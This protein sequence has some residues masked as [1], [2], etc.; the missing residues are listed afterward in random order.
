[1]S[2][3]RVQVV[4]FKRDLRIADHAPLSLAA[5]RGPVLPLYVV[6]PG[7]WQQPDMAARHWAFIGESLHELNEALAGLGQPLVVR[8]GDVVEV[9]EGLRKSLHIDALWSHEETGNAWSYRRDERVRAYLAARGIN[10]HELPQNGVVRRLA[11]RDGW[12]RRWE[13]RMSEPRAVPPAALLPLDGLVTHEMPGPAALGLADDPCPGRQPGGRRAGLER[14]GSFLDSRG[15]NYHTGMSSPVTA[16][17][18]CSRLSPHLAWGCL[19]IREVVQACRERRRE[20]KAQPASE[21]GG[22]AKALAAFEGR[23]HW[24]CHFIQK[25]ESEP[26]IEFENLHRA[27]DGLREAE[28]DTARFG[29]WC[30]AETGFPF[31]DACLRALEATG[32]I[33]FRMRA[34]L[35]SFASYH[36]W[37]HWREP[38]LFLARRFTDYEPGI[39]YAQA[40]MQAG[41]TGINTFRIY[42]PVK[43]SQDQDPSGRFIRE[44]LP[45]LARVEE[46]W[47]HTPWLM[48]DGAQRDSGCLIGRDYPEPLVDH[49]AAARLARQRMGGLR[50]GRARDESRRILER[51]GS[52]RGG[53]AAGGPKAAGDSP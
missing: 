46:R 27:C 50:R 31:V 6:E 48:D 37:L 3:P 8:T 28:F 45:E 2:R 23:L 19:S 17:S 36:L 26:R 43:Q 53:L 42:N 32:W 13:A 22:W 29:A 51:H 1:M 44:W 35:M 52:R 24:H 41:T 15:E 34:M 4:W 33:N 21:R 25:L 39:H 30:R 38:S 5:E 16:F 14:L 40:Q 12:S 20:V 18:A 11:S 47:I 9:L 7:L 49:M 10:W